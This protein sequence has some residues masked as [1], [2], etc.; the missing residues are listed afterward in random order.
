MARAIWNGAII[1]EAAKY[2]KLEG[3]VY[4]PP[5]LLHREYLRPSRHDARCTRLCEA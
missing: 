4:F 5:E 2:V 1:A 3:N